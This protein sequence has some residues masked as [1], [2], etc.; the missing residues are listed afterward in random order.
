M[1]GGEEEPCS[2]ELHPLM[3]FSSGSSVTL[4]VL[5]KYINIKLV[6][7]TA[8]LEKN[9]ANVARRFQITVYAKCRF[10]AKCFAP[11]FSSKW[12]LKTRQDKT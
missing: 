7:K 12:D 4:R 11:L 3:S 5:K 10:N 2:H 9:L 6:M 8:K 1:E